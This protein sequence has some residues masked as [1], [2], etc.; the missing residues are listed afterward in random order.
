MNPLGILKVLT[1]VAVSTS[2]GAVVGNAVKAST[3]A[4]ASLAQKISITVGGFVLSGLVGSFASEHATEQID[5]TTEQ[6][7]QFKTAFKQHKKN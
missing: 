4:N 6:V 1:D 3:P 5:V 2:V 7:K